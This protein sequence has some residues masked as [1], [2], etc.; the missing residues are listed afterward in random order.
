MAV[1]NTVHLLVGEDSVE[2]SGPV[3][4]QVSQVLQDLVRNQRELYLDQFSGE[5]D[6]IQDVVEILYGG[7]VVLT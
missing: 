3:I 7:D 5:I 6:G 1:Y 4:S 2:V